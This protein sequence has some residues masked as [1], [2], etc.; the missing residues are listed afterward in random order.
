MYY[1]KFRVTCKLA[2]DTY[3]TMS[4]SYLA[5]PARPVGMSFNECTDWAAVSSL[6][7]LIG[8][9]QCKYYSGLKCQSRVDSVF[10]AGI[11][12][13]KGPFITGIGILASRFTEDTLEEFHLYKAKRRSIHITRAEGWRTRV[14]IG[15]HLKTRYGR[16]FH[17]RVLYLSLIFI[18]I[19]L[20]ACAAYIHWFI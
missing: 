8:S 17:C 3:I 4:K 5:N 10:L 13:C 1:T 20:S 19:Y 7:T 2:H 14:E 15:D 18:S 9:Y 11:W 6:F 16:Y 12:V